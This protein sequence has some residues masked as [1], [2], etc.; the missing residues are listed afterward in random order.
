MTRNPKKK[1]TAIVTGILNA[2]MATT[3]AK[4]QD[5]APAMCAFQRSAP[6]VTSMHTMGMK[7][8]SPFFSERIRYILL[9]DQEKDFHKFYVD[10]AI[11]GNPKALELTVEYFGVDRVL[12]GTDLPDRKSVV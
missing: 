9:E 4:A 11:L 5:T 1:E 8:T 10:T 7:A 6:R 2:R 3:K 12:F